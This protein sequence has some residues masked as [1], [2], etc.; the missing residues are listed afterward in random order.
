MNHIKT[1]SEVFFLKQKEN[2]ILQKDI[3]IRNY[4]KKNYIFIVDFFSRYLLIYIYLSLSFIFL[5][6]LLEF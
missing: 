1:K 5:R 4:D 6:L 2:H 3:S